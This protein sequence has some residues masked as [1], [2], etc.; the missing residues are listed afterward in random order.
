VIVRRISTGFA[1]ALA[2]AFLSQLVVPTGAFE[3]AGKLGKPTIHVVAVRDSRVLT[4]CADV[5]EVTFANG[6]TWKADGRAAARASSDDTQTVRLA[7][8]ADASEREA[9]AYDGNRDARAAEFIASHVRM[10]LPLGA[11]SRL[12]PAD[13]PNPGRVELGSGRLVIDAAIGARIE[14]ELQNLGKYV[15]VDSLAQADFV[16]LIEVTYAAMSSSTTDLT[17][18]T[19][20]TGRASVMVSAPGDWEPNLIQS[21]LAIV[22]PAAAYRAGSATVQGLLAGRVWEG[23]SLLVPPFT[24]RRTVPRDEADGSRSTVVVDQ[25][26]KTW[27]S[28]SPESVVRQFHDK[29]KRPSSHP[30]LCQASNGPTVAELKRAASDRGTKP[31]MATPAGARARAG[32]EQQTSPDL[33]DTPSATT[34][35]S[36]VTYVSLPLVVTDAAGKPVLDVKPS[37]VRVFEDDAPQTLDQLITTQEPFS[38]ALLID[39]SDSMRARREDAESAATTLIGAVPAGDRILLAS[40]NGRIFVETEL[41]ADRGQLRSAIERLSRG[42]PTRLYDAIDLVFA[43]RLSAL[44]GRK[45]LVILTDGVDTFSRMSNVDRT[46]ATIGESHVPVYAVQY[47]TSRDDTAPVSAAI[48]V[49]KP[50][51]GYRPP[52]PGPHTL[53]QPVDL[54]PIVAPNGARDR[55]V[56]AQRAA[57]YLWDITAASGG[58]LYRAWTLASLTGAFAQ[59][60]SDLGTLYTVSFYPSNQAHDGTTRRIRVELARSGTTARTRASY[61]APSR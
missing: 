32:I 45:A 44:P 30:A 43:E 19:G 11:P 5:R 2:V 59:V 26:R 33:A 28:A 6:R 7:S 29:E 20:G 8:R 16:F 47:D 48:L 15:P 25:S 41:T 49:Q 36:A 10:P 22:V 37:E 24:Y 18:Y 3:A 60:A 61:R 4:M 50:P 9:Q 55:Q 56:V 54:K 21:A 35:R 13:S 31:S 14:K 52:G 40:F 46:L 57:G 39:T 12:A 23:S 51:Q 1:M 38:I 53:A 42:V 58:R 17:S 27:T 34:F